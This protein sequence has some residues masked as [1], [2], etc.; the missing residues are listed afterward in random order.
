VPEQPGQTSTV[1]NVQLKT[2]TNYY[3]RAQ[4]SDPLNGVTTAF[5]NGL[6]FTYS[7]FDMRQ[8][9]I[10]N[11]PPDLGSWPET[12]SITFIQ[13]GNGNFSFD[14]DKRTGPNRWPDVPFGPGGSLQFTLGMCLNIGGHW[15]CSAPIQYWYGRDTVASANIGQDWFY[16]P[17]RWGPMAGHQPG[18]GEQVGF[19]VAAGNL[20]NI[21][22]KNQGSYAVERSHVLMLPWG[23]NYP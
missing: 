17:A 22:D 15:N 3:W 18:Y 5:T 4:A 11:N 7:S 8:A 16:D 10:W 9:S 19:F 13:F 21:S 12:T 14:F 2:G 20:R 1:V 6:N 23:Q